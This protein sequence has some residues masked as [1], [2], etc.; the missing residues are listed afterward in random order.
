MLLYIPA[1]LPPAPQIDISMLPRSDYGTHLPNGSQ[2][3]D[4]YKLTPSSADDSAK[5]QTR[6]L[7]HEFI[8]NNPNF[9]DWAKCLPYKE[10]INVKI[11]RQKN[12]TGGVTLHVDLLRPQ[13]DILHY[14]HLQKN[15]PAG[16]RSILQG[17]LSDTTYILGPNDE[18]MY[19]NMPSDLSTNTYIMNYTT[20]IHGVEADY[21]RIIL[22]FQLELDP[23]KNKQLVKESVKKYKE[24]EVSVMVDNLYY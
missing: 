17:R 3:W 1:A 22:F 14:H 5:Y 16:Y 9:L 11:H 20:A 4:L 24:F 7:K 2:P 12:L 8:E 21:G 19:C 13:R 23:I 18:K 6:D 10:F 15:E